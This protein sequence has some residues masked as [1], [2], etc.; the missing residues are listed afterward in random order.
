MLSLGA[1]AFATPWTLLGLAALPAIWWLLRIS[2]PLPKRVR[3][4]AIRLLV[5]LDRDEETPANT[6]LCRAGRSLVEPR[7]HHRR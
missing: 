7:A 5:G 3:F 1:L 4:P 2:P 6:P